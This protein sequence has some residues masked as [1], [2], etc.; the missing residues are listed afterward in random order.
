MGEDPLLHADQEHDGPDGKQEADVIF[1][2]QW[3]LK[4][5]RKRSTGRAQNIVTFRREPKG[6]RIV[7]EKQ[8]K[9]LKDR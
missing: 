3:T 9:I 4:R 8:I 6:W 1:D 7:S 5:G 2:R